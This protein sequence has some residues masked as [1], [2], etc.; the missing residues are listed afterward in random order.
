MLKSKILQAVLNF[1]IKIFHGQGV[2]AA[3]VTE[4]P[5]DWS[6]TRG[7]SHPGESVNRD[8]LFNIASIGKDFLAAWMLKLAEDGQLTLNDPIYGSMSA[9][10]YFPKLKTGLV[11]L[12]NENNQPFQYGVSFGSLI[13]TSLL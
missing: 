13:V 7:Y 12:T 1:T 3:I 8:M 11:V 5:R 2:S 10:L 9:M 6:G 4:D